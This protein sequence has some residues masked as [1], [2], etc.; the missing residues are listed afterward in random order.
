MPYDVY[1]CV[2]TLT[3]RFFFVLFQDVLVYSVYCVYWP[4]IKTHLAGNIYCISKCD[5]TS[6]G[7]PSL[8]SVTSIHTVHISITSTR[9]WKWPYIPKSCIYSRRS[10]HKEFHMHLA[11]LAKEIYPQHQLRVQINTTYV[12]MPIVRRLI[13]QYPTPINR[14]R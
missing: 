2:F 14:V 9:I 6:N 13:T 10:R 3:E 11:L 12:C 1:S 4:P 5:I 8:A 7:T